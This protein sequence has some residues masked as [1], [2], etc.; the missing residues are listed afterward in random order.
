MK[1]NINPNPT[2]QKKGFGRGRKQRKCPLIAGTQTFRRRGSDHIYQGK[3]RQGE[4]R[5]GAGKNSKR[6]WV[7]YKLQTRNSNN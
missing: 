1:L 7:K 3:D 6:S 4:N 2:T 5:G